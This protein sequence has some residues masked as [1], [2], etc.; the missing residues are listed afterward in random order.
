MC[1]FAGYLHPTRITRLPVLGNIA[2]LHVCWNAAT[3]KTINKI[4]AHPH[5]RALADVFDHPLSWLV[6]VSKMTY[7]LSSG[8]LNSSIP[9]H[10][11]LESRHP[12]WSDMTLVY[13]SAQWRENRKWW[14]WSITCLLQTLAARIPSIS[15]FMIIDQ[16]FLDRPKPLLRV[17]SITLVA[18][19]APVVIFF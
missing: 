17:S 6:P 13:I 18:Q 14:L 9:Y 8:T 1:L 19:Q 16:P 12:M 7:T 5:W 2:P 4:S 10:S 11:W 15:P 3:D